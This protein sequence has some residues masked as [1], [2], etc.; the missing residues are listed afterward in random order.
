MKTLREIAEAT[1][2]AHGNDARLAAP[3]FLALVEKANLLPDLAKAYL[4]SVRQPGQGS[5]RVKT[6]QVPQ[7]RRRTS[8]EKA[9]ADEAA[10]TS[11][12]AVFGLRIGDRAIGDIAM[13]ELTE[14]R[15]DLI[16]DAIDKLVLGTEQVRNAI[17]AEKIQNH[18][19]VPDQLMRVRDAIDAATLQRLITEAENET[20]RKL[21]QAMDRATEVFSQSAMEQIA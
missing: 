4:F 9:A 7:Y 21:R 19:V 6:Y 12:E 17:L 20:P 2:K 1:L 8:E 15:R 10:R 3:K 18:V 13:G 11:I 14:L 5:I 16:Q